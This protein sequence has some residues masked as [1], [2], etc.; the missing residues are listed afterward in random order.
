MATCPLLRVS[1][2]SRGSEVSSINKSMALRRLLSLLCSQ[3]KT[4]QAL[5]IN[6]EAGGAAACRHSATRCG[7]TAST[8]VTSII[9]GK[10]D[11][12]KQIRP[13]SKNHNSTT[14]FGC[15]HP[16]I[17]LIATYRVCAGA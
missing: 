5:Q 16:L 13:T 3:G 11:Q 7:L 17:G 9:E 10:H 12:S 1:G 6:V 14:P 2:R 15:S 4:R 8:L